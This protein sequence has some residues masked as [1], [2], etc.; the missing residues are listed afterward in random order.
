MLEKAQ[1]LG[2]YLSLSEE[3]L[4]V[5]PE[6]S[7][8]YRTVICA[9][10]LSHKLD[11]VGKLLSC[12]LPGGLMVATENGKGWHEIDWETLLEESRDKY[13]FTIDSLTDTVRNHFS[14]D[15]SI[16]SSG[17]RYHKYIGSLRCLAEHSTGDATDY[18]S[19][20]KDPTVPDYCGETPEDWCFEGDFNSTADFHGV[21]YSANGGDGLGRAPSHPVMFNPAYMDAAQVTALQEALRTMSLGPNDG[22]S[23]ADLDVLDAVF[24][25]P[26][27]TIIDTESHLGT[28]G[29]SIENVPG[30][31]AYFN[32]KIA[33]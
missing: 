22:G 2:V 16:P 9:G 11:L 32:E 31:E 4:S 30:I 26:G 10:V 3:D 24:S 28:Y 25:T 15:S 20:A 14:E 33:N 8:V 19:F 12:P 23:Q 29:D 21:N 27:F 13:G 5:N 1:S 7:R 18:I 6:P 17:T